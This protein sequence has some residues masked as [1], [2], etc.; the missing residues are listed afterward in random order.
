V[1][2]ATGAVHIIRIAVLG[3]GGIGGYDATLL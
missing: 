1:A 3:A 2:D